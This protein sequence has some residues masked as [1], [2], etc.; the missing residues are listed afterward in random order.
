MELRFGAPL[1]SRLPVWNDPFL[2][3]GKCQTLVVRDREGG[4]EGEEIEHSSWI[5][6]AHNNP[7]IAGACYMNQR[8]VSKS[9]CLNIL[10]HFM[11][12]Q[13]HGTILCIL[14]GSCIL[15]A[16]SIFLIRS[17]MLDK[18]EKDKSCLL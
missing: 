13:L 16:S 8:I 4:G 18:N 6:F 11:P 15:V 9:N 1:Q 3:D 2:D 17:C 5:T 7:E 14:N 12:M 10:A